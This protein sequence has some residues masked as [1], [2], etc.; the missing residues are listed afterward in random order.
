MLCFGL[1]QRAVFG[2]SVLFLMLTVLRIGALDR[3]GTPMLGCQPG[4]LALLNQFA[5]S[6]S[7]F[8]TKAGLWMSLLLPC[9]HCRSV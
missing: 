5:W 9:L 8:P 6:A 3:L 1:A 7:T 4:C 2:L